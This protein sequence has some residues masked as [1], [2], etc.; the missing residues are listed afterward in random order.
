MVAEREERRMEAELLMEVPTPP[1]LP[2][3]LLVLAL[4]VSGPRKPLS[5][6]QIGTDVHPVHMEPSVG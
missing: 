3:I 1:S 5:P 2:Q 4:K 6:W